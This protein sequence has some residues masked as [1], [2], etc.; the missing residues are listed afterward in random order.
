M[1]IIYHR[2][3]TGRIY[4]CYRF[5]GVSAETL[6]RL[7]NEYNLA[8]ASDGDTVETLELEPNSI[9]EYLYN[10]AYGRELYRLDTLKSLGRALEDGMSM[11]DDLIQ[12]VK[13]GINDP[14]DR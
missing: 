14:Q 10:K 6:E 11:I 2:K 1:T 3:K 13:E 5:N 12:Q 4:K 9:A 7:R 8:H